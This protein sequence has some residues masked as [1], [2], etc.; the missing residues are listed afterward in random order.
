MSNKDFVLSAQSLFDFLCSHFGYNWEDVMS[1]N[2][3]SGTIGDIRV[4]HEMFD[5]YKQI[6]AEDGF[7]AWQQ[8]ISILKDAIDSR[9]CCSTTEEL[10]NYAQFLYDASDFMDRYEMVREN[11]RRDWLIKLRSMDLVTA[12]EK[13]N[14]DLVDVCPRSM[15]EDVAKMVMNKRYLKIARYKGDSPL[16]MDKIKSVRVAENF[17]MAN[18]V[19]QII[20]QGR[21]GSPEE[22]N[23]YISL[24]ID[25]VLD[26][27]YFIIA[28][29]NGGNWWLVTDEPNFTNPAAKKGI[30]G[31]GSFRYRENDFD[32]TIFPY[33]FIDRIIEWRES[34]KQID[35]ADGVKREMYTTPLADWPLQCR[36]MLNLLIEQLIPKFREDDGLIQRMKFGYEFSNDLL[37]ENKNYNPDEWKRRSEYFDFEDKS[38]NSC[39]R[40]ENMIFGNEDSRAIIPVSVSQLTEKISA[41]NSCLMTLDKFSKLE[42]WALCDIEYQRKKKILEDIEKNRKEDERRMFE[43]LD[44]NFGNRVDYLFAARQMYVFI[45]EP[46]VVYG[47]SEGSFNWKRSVSILKLHARKEETFYRMDIPGVVGGCEEDLCDRCKKYPLKKNHTS[48]L[49]VYHYAFLAWLAGVNREQLPSWFVNYTG[50][51]YDGYFGNH[52]LDNINPM[53]M[54]KDELSRRCPNGLNFYIRVCQ[55]CRTSMNK[56]AMDKGV[57]VINKLTC[58]LEGLFSVSDFKAWLE[59]KG[60]DCECRLTSTY[61]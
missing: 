14:V 28:F 31:R 51:M 61:I 29:N 12:G 55:R 30:A 39:T 34:G 36:V 15:S 18:N 38:A 1:R 52:L 40:I 24:N 4:Q 27:S 11:D 57:L 46:D 58:E 25:D 26:F 23:V 7:L 41:W 54:L 16:Q 17:V 2:N 3:I 48:V 45:Y 49:Y 8:G 6:Q 60:F 9:R 19:G 5:M 43:M 47:D 59:G 21:D 37:L 10:R 53:Y 50:F 56:L 32:N 35:L 22:L 33:I 13:E 44:R 20:M 42:A